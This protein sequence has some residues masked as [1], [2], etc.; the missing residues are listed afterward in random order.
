MIA[1]GPLDSQGHLSGMGPKLDVFPKD[2]I[3]GSYY[4]AGG[5][6]Q[7]AREK[8]FPRLHEKGIDFFAQAWIYSHLWL[9]PWVNWWESSRGYSHV[10]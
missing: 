8:D 4:C 9:I 7:P 3:I 2:V 10:V 5:P 1:Q 6:Y